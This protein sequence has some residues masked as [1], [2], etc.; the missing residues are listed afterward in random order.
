MEKFEFVAKVERLTM[1]TRTAYVARNWTGRWKPLE[2]V[3]V[4]TFRTPEGKVFTWFT[5]GLCPAKEGETVEVKGTF[6]KTEFFNGEERTVLTRCTV[7][8]MVTEVAA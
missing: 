7:T 4:F 6:K 3:K 8:A 5:T 1:F 2:T